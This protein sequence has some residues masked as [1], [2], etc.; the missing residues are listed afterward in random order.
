MPGEPQKVQRDGDVIQVA[1]LVATE[2]ASSR[3][4]PVRA[5]STRDVRVFLRHDHVDSNYARG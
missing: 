1:D 3:R 5:C 2:P 4:G